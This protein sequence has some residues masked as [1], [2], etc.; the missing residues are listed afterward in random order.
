MEGKASYTLWIWATR[1]SENKGT[2]S[3]LSIRLLTSFKI[4]SADGVIGGSGC[5]IARGG[6]SC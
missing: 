5:V 4:S 6:K 2:T 1:V 3:Y